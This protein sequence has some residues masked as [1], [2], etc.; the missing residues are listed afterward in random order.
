MGQTTGIAFPSAYGGGSGATGGSGGTVYHVTNLL[1]DG[2][3]G[4][5]RWAIA[6]PRPAIIVFDVSGTIACTNYMLIQGANLTIAGQTAPVG[7]ITFTFANPNYLFR[8]WNVE[9]MIV[10]YIRIR[11]QSGQGVIGLDVYGNGTFAKN[12]IFDHVS[13]GYAGWTG[14]GLRGSNSFNVTFQNGL[15]AECKTGSI[16]GD[17]D[18]SFST[19]SYD[20]SMLNTFWYNTSHRFPNP[21]SVGRVDVINNV[22]QNPFFRMDSNTHSPQLN[23]INNYVAAGSW[24]GLTFPRM[25]RDFD[26]QNAQIYTAGNIIDKGIFTDANADNKLIW[27]KWAAGSE[28]AYLPAANFTSTQWA[29][30]NRAYPIKTAAQAYNDVTTNQDLGASKSLNADGS[31]SDSRDAN[32]IAYFTKIAEGEGAFES[33]DT[34]TNWQTTPPNVFVTQRYTDFIASISSTPVN[35]RAAGY[36]TNGD[37]IP[38]VWRAA[39]MSGQLATDLAPSGYTWLEEFLN[40]VDGAI[41]GSIPIITLVGVST[42]NLNNGDTYTE[43]GATA[44]DTEDGSLT[45]SIVTTGTVNTAVDGTYYKYYNVADSN[46]NNA[47]QIVRTINVT[48]PGGGNIT[49][50]LTE[51]QKGRNRFS[52]SS[53]KWI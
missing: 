53:I 3:T 18:T 44:S 6:Q 17:S 13:I 48:T 32:D 36:N 26:G 35:T 27:S 11:Y 7:G 28:V 43:S 12:L 40:S 25:N 52:K 4:S 19:V 1:D 50:T 46:S 39:N 47:V 8:M 31:V 34:S 14:F 24:T 2:S 30:I 21:N 15:I 37:G 16:F 49:H 9:N 38:D 45:G 42:I 5:F 23:H 10:R 51:L 22:V 41:V 33:Y 20:N 29:L